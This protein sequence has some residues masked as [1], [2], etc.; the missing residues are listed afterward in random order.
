MTYI[1]RKSLFNLNRLTFIWA[2]HSIPRIW[3]FCSSITL[4]SIT[5]IF[6]ATAS[7]LKTWRILLRTVL[8]FVNKRI[9]TSKFHLCSNI[10]QWNHPSSLNSRTKFFP[11]WKSVVRE[12]RMS[13]PVERERELFRSFIP[14]VS[15]CPLLSIRSQKRFKWNSLWNS[16][17]CQ[18]RSKCP[19]PID[20][21][22]FDFH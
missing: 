4:F 5:C 22:I 18:I 16:P 10:I 7:W 9:R 19:I 13:S 11:N 14:C 3:L 8:I 21:A 20:S 1:I 17:S 2:H 6:S 15:C 12:P